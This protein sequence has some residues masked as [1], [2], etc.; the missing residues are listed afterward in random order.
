MYITDKLFTALHEVSPVC[1]IESINETETT[2]SNTSSNTSCENSDL[3]N[4]EERQNNGE[5][6]YISVL[7]KHNFRKMEDHSF[8]K[9]G[10]DLYEHNLS[11][12]NL[13][14]QGK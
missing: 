10:S 14:F 13:T 5:V 4:T 8:P 3:V 1:N 2:G 7:N 12:T 6:E 9:A 11:S